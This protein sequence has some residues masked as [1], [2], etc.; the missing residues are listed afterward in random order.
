M[1]DALATLQARFTLGCSTLTLTP[2]LTCTGALR[3]A[4]E[5]RGRPAAD[6][7]A[8]RRAAPGTHPDPDPNPH[9]EPNPNPHPN[10]H[11]D[12]DR[13]PNPSP[14]PNPNPHPDPDPNP[15]PRPYP[16]PARGLR[17]ARRG[18]GAV[19]QARAAE[20]RGE[21]QPGGPNL[22]PNPN[23]SLCPMCLQPATH[24]ASSLQLIAPPARSPPAPHQVFGKNPNPNPNPNP[25]Q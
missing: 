12:P 2:T 18:R 16:L 15:K 19:L 8:A 21:L 3:R 7:R 9:P 13:H 5:L 1:H 11:P 17:A 25:N 23:P 14:D 20:P 22:N 4:R 10:P 24:C 6:R